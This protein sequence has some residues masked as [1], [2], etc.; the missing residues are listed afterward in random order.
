MKGSDVFDSDDFSSKVTEIRRKLIP[1][2]KVAR[3]KEEEE[4][5]EEEEERERERENYVLPRFGLANVS[6]RSG[7]SVTI[8]STWESRTQLSLYHPPST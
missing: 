3:K 8:R 2:L 1:H 4:E 5:E 6:V 7:S